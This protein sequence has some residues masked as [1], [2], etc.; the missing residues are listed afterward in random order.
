M[1]K[2]YILLV[3]L[4]STARVFNK[5]SSKGLTYLD[6]YLANL[7]LSSVLTKIQG[8]KSTQR[9]F[10]TEA[11]RNRHVIK[12]TKIRYSQAHLGLRG[13]GQRVTAVLGSPAGGG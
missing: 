13:K 2:T 10:H 12:S 11:S 4:L 5:Q 9:S 3:L 1:I 8:Q 7:K 6:L